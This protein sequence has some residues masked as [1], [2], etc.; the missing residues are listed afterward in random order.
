LVLLTSQ[1][2]GAV[3][4]RIG[5]PK[6]V[7]E[8]LVG[9]VLGPS[10]LNLIEPGEFLHIFSEIGVLLL[11]FIAGMETDFK[12]LMANLKPSIVVALFGVIVPLV[13]FSLFGKF[14]HMDT[15]QALFVGIIF[16]ATSVSITVKIFMDNNILQ[17]KVAAIVL[18]AAVIDDILAVLAISIYKSVDNLSTANLLSIAWD[19]LITKLIFF[20]S[21]YLFYKFVLPWLKHYSEKWEWSFL[22]VIMTLIACFLW[23]YFAELMG[24]SAVLGS[25]FFGLMLA[26][27][28]AK[29]HIEKEIDV[30]ANSIFIPL[31]LTSIGAAITLSD[32][33]VNLVPILIG[34]LLAII[35]KLGSCYFAA[36]AGKLTHPEAL[37]I[38]SG[39]MSRG[40][41]ALVTLNI[42]IS[43]HF[44]GEQY[45]SILVAIIVMTTILSPFFIKYSLQKIKL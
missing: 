5:L 35:T 21:V 27:S 17:T 12:K 3:A 37:L 39:M 44:I 29:Q 16:S 25:F 45:Y 33:T 15:M 22:P 8:L 6:I 18:G 2:F 1:I 14:L 32:I 42:G 4:T 38:G 26:I 30:I 36:K 10:L 31:F 20:L 13:A 28:G 24:L 43:M 34:T 40:E 7:G 41:M 9:V 11:M 23:G 19:L